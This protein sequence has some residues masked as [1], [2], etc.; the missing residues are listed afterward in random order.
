MGNTYKSRAA[1]R[2]MDNLRWLELTFNDSTW[3]DLNDFKRLKIMKNDLKD[4]IDLID[5]GDLM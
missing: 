5:I 2:D 4:E 3:N 1:M